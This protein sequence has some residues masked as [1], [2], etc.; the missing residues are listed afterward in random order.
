MSF[1]LSHESIPFSI[2][3]LLQTSSSFIWNIILLSEVSLLIYLSPVPIGPIFHP[4]FY[5]YWPTFQTL[6]TSDEVFPFF[7]QDSTQ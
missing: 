1:Q 3:L 6:N 5:P 4:V 2:S 7:L